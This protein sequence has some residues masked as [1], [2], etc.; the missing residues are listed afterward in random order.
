[1]TEIAAGSSF[2]T[3]GAS[4]PRNALENLSISA[5]ELKLVVAQWHL[6]SYAE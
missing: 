4:T 2:Q 3:T 1:M 6:L 5:S